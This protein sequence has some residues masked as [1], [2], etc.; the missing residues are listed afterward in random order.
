MQKPDVNF[1]DIANNYT[2]DY[3]SDGGRYTVI[4][5]EK[6]NGGNVAGDEVGRIEGYNGHWK[7]KND[8]TFEGSILI[9][10]IKKVIDTYLRFHLEFEYT[11]S[12]LLNAKSEEES[13]DK[14]A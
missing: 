8:P 10:A 7:I 9:K 12:E 13:S 6:L 11:R 2:I 4:V 5:F 3:I 1:E 14:E